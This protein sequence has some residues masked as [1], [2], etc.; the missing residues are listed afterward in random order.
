MGKIISV[1]ALI[2]LM[3]MPMVA[4]TPKQT[5]TDDYYYVVTF[6]CSQSHYTL[7]LSEHLKDSMNK[8]KFEV[9]VDKDFYDKVKVGDTIN[10]S[11]RMGSF[12]MKG[13]I[14]KWKVKIVDKR[15]VPK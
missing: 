4:E 14:G 13:S 7:D 1:L 15:K 5:Q 12:I 3:A 8:V 11:F 2:V 10:D 9:P 6:E